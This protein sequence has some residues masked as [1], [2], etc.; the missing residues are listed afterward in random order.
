MDILR[1]AVPGTLLY[2]GVVLRA[3]ALVCRVVRCGAEAGQATS[4]RNHVEDFDDEVVSA[5]SEAFN[6]IAIHAYKSTRGEAELELAFEQDRLTVR[7]LDTGEGF[8]FSAALGQDLEILRESHM[9]LE[10]MLACMDEVS[11]ARGGPS[12]PNVLTMTKRYANAAAS[13]RGDGVP[14]VHA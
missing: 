10:I 13:T 8:D 7:L 11:Y 1:L 3:V 9:G 6:N 2:R 5:V 14:M 4:H 12:T